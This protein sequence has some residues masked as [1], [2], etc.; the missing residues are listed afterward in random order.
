MAGVVRDID[1]LRRKLVTKKE[2]D[3]SHK[4]AHDEAER[5]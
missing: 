1:V 5:L 2:V 4:A 3:A